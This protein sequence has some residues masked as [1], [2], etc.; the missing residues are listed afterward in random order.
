MI[1]ENAAKNSSFLMI[2]A[3]TS[4]SAGYAAVIA[5]SS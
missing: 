5:A 3:R 2:L 4:R 1:G